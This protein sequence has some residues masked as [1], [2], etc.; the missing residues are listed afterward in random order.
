MKNK[1]KI[2]SKDKSKNI[3]KDNRKKFPKIKDLTIVGLGNPGE[4]YMETRHNAGRM[5][6]FD[7]ASKNGFSDF[8]DNKSVG[9][10]MAKG[11]IGNK[12]TI[13]FLPETF[14]NKSGLAVIKVIKSKEPVGLLVIHDDLDLPLG[15]LKIS[16]NRGSGGHRGV[17]SIVKNLKTNLFFRARIGVSKSTST[18]KIKKPQGEDQVAKFILGRFSPDELKVLKKVFIEL[19]QKISVLAEKGIEAMISQ[20]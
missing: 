13:L 14:M 1:D 9:A 20:G 10:L 4:E 19:N 7:F 2:K 5:A 6:V 18:G 3:K 12:K 11:K 16:F 8:I 17:D 15:K